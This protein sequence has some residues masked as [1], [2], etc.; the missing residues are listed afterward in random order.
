MSPKTIRQRKNES[1]KEYFG[2]FKQS[3]LEIK[4]LQQVVVLHS[5]LIGLGFN[6]FSKSLA[7]KLVENLVALF[8][9]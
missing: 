8:V 9:W 7:K 6:D 1:L 4:D 3:T 5:I 2:Q